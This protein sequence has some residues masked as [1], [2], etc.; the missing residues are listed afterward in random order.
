[1]SVEHSELKANFS[2][3]YNDG[4]DRENSELFLK[5]RTYASSTARKFSDFV[6]ILSSNLLSCELLH[7][8]TP[9]SKGLNVTSILRPS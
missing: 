9:P 5:R 6:T 3:I 7:A 8:H 2:K 1:M 4:R